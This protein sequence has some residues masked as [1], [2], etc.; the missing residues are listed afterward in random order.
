MFNRLFS[1]WNTRG[2]RIIN[3]EFDYHTSISEQMRGKSWDSSSL[4]MFAEKWAYSRYRTRRYCTLHTLD[5]AVFLNPG[6]TSCCVRIFVL[7]Y[8][9]TSS[10]NIF[11]ETKT[12]QSFALEEDASFTFS[13]IWIDSEMVSKFCSYDGEKFVA[14]LMTTRHLQ[15]WNDET[16]LK[17]IWGEDPNLRRLRSRNICIAESGAGLKRT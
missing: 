2:N 13:K 17:S 8:L 6:R 4:Q 15:F 12:A 11:L 1:V 9:S 14:N 7:P 10:A 3:F 5:P 16:F